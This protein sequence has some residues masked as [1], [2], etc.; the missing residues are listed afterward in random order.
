MATDELD[1]AALA[2]TLK[3]SVSADSYLPG[4][5]VEVYEGEQ[6]GVLGKTVTVRGDIITLKVEE[7]E[8]KGQTIDAPVK[9]LRKRFREGDHVKVIGGS[10]S[11]T[12]SVWLFESRM[13]V[14]RL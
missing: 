6:K 1:L 2:K 13:S 9:T 11:G 3:N 8:L 10:D 14:S 12:K 7:G 4:D 5:I